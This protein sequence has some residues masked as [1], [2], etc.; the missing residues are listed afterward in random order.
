MTAR[1]KCIVPRIYY[2]KEKLRGACWEYQV[3]G[4]WMEVATP[5]GPMLIRAEELGGWWWGRGMADWRTW[6]SDCVQALTL[7]ARG[8]RS[9]AGNPALQGPALLLVLLGAVIGAY[10]SGSQP[11]SLAQVALLTPV[12]VAGFAVTVLIFLVAGRWLGG[13]ASY[14]VLFR[15]LAFANVFALVSF[16]GLIPG[17][18]QTANT[19]AAVLFYVAEWLGAQQ[20]LRLRGWKAVFLPIATLIMF[21]AMLVIPYILFSGGSLAITDIL[22]RFGLTSPP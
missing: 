18:G 13:K 14:T 8:F 20:A 3:T 5:D 9:I 10:F 22:A 2:R 15:T 4:G 17:L 1:P 16:L 19:L 12:R 11:Q 6:L 7:S 21:G